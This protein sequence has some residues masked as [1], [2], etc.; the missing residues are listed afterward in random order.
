[1]AYWVAAFTQSVPSPKSHFGFSIGENYMLANYSQTEAYFRKVAAS[2]DRAKL[3]DIGS[4]EE[5]RRQ[6]MF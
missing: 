1:M 4:T 6:L 3:V 5:G 2:S